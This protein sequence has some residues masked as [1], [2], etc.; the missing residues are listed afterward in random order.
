MAG[1]YVIAGKAIPNH[2]ISIGFISA[3][4][5]AGVAFTMRPKAAQPATPPIKASST[6]EEAFIREFLKQ[7]ETEKN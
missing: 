3:Y 1:H 7:A 4:A 6:D 2:L 5:A